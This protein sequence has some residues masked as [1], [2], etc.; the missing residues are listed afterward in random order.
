MN[1]KARGYLASREKAERRAAATPTMARNDAKVFALEGSFNCPLYA[2]RED[3]RLD[4]GAAASLRSERTL[5]FVE[6]TTVLDGNEV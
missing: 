5:A 1:A 3:A 6:Y 2:L 4:P